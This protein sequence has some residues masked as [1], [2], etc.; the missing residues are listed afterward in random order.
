MVVILGKIGR[1][2]FDGAGEIHEFVR[3]TLGIVRIRR[4]EADRHDRAVGQW[5]IIFKHD[6]AAPYGAAQGMLG[7]PLLNFGPDLHPG[8]ARSGS[9]GVLAEAEQLS[10]ILNPHRLE[11]ALRLF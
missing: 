6:D 11:G 9:Q 7:Q 1:E 4:G 8:I 10:D 5:H 3:E 2:A